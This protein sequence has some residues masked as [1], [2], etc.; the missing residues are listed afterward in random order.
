[1]CWGGAFEQKLSAQFKCPTYACPPPPPPPP[2]Q[3]QL[4]ID[5]CVTVMY[6][7]IP[8][9]PMPPRA[10]PRAFDFCEKFWSNSS[11][12]CHFRR[13]NAPPVRTSKRVKSPTLQACEAN[14]GPGLGSRLKFNLISCTRHQAIASKRRDK[15]LASFGSR[16][17]T[18][19]PLTTRT[20][21]TTTYSATRKELK[22]YSLASLYLA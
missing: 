15:T 18:L 6:R 12:C 19:C 10:K 1:M 21:N 3:Q 22:L 7:S 20:Y 9:P 4:N 11:L 5:R 17:G 14:C 2:N 16:C 8:K 13:S